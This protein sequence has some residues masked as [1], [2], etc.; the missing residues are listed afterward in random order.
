VHVEVYESVGTAT[1][2]GNKL[3]TSQLAFP[4]DVCAEVYATEGCEG[5]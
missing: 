3:R 2:A 4:A 5:R 1:S